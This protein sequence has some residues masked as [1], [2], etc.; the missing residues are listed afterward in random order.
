MNKRKSIVFLTLCMLFI[1]FALGSGESETKR[2]SVKIDS[3][4]N[5]ETSDSGKGSG[6]E[7]KSSIKYEIT[8]TGF[9]YYTNSIGIVEYFGFVELTNT[10]TCD[11]YLDDCTFDLEDNSGHLLQSDSFISNCPSVIS[12]GEK[13]YFYNGMGATNIDSGVSFDNGVKLVPQMKLKKANG[14]PAKYPV[15]DISVREGDYGYIKITGRVE[16]TSGKDINYLYVTIIFQDKNGKV[17][18]FDGTSITD[19]G[20]GMKGSFDTTTYFANDNLKLENIANTI[21]IAEETY[22]QW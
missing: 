6:S 2:D 21:V 13:G 5:Q 16:N 17:I 4:G 8:D 19:I 18:G 15:S 7:D 9:Q 20:A 14:K 22:Y 10:G 1:V 3:D 12:P 11:I